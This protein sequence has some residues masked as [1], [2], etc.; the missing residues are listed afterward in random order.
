MKPLTKAEQKLLYDE[1]IPLN[2][3]CIK[4]SEIKDKI[5]YTLAI[6]ALYNQKD[7][8]ITLKD[9]NLSR[10]QFF[11]QAFRDTLKI[12]FKD[13]IHSAKEFTSE[14][15]LAYKEHFLYLISFDIFTCSNNLIIAN[16]F[17]K[18][19]EH[20]QMTFISLDKINNSYKYTGTTA[21]TN[22]GYKE[23]LETYFKSCKKQLDE[24]YALHVT[25]NEDKLRVKTF[26]FQIKNFINHV[27]IANY[28]IVM[29]ALYDFKNLNLNIEEGIQKGFSQAF[30]V[31]NGLKTT[32]PT[33]LRSFYIKVAFPY[34]NKKIN[35]VRLCHILKDIAREFFENVVYDKKK[36]KY[37]VGISPRYLK[38]N[39]YIKTA[40]PQGNT[41]Y[42]YDTNDEYTFLWK[43]NINSAIK[44]YSKMLIEEGYEHITKNRTY[45][46]LIK[47]LFSTPIFPI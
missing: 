5:N 1:L 14:Q 45:K 11:E 31:L 28:S 37:I 42:A 24:N 20:I 40:I 38:K 4:K 6:H 18:F 17:Y 33:L 41:I 22:T 29:N 10:G 13:N 43:M 16:Y 25:S 35:K 34:K 46:S 27:E 30:K 12:F 47:K 23:G 39:V 19:M 26:K 44:L 21:F 36:R 32:A 8:S 2:L 3:D 9:L 15:I 7:F